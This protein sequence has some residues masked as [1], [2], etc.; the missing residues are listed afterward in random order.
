[1]SYKILFLDIDGTILKPDHKYTE[2][3]KEAIKQVKAK[4]IEVFFA[5]GRPLHEIEDL[6]EELEIESGIG[7]N[8]G[9]AKYKGEM[10][11][12]DAFRPE[13][14]EEISSLAKELGNELIFYTLGTNYLTD[15]EDPE[16]E[17]FIDLFTMKK[18]A[19]VPEDFS[20]A[21]YGLS[22][23]KVLPEHVAHYEKFDELYMSPVNV[24]R[25]KNSYDFIQKKT[26]KGTAIQQ[27]LEKL[28]ISP[29]EAIAFGD[30]MNDK[31]MLQLVGHSFA[32][33]N[34]H[35]NV[36]QY[37]KYKTTSVNEDGIYNGLKE[38]GLVK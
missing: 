30:G 24:G 19:R 16:M 13:L 32:M 4:G 33:G 29:D 2:S 27:V 8:G 11:V 5:T 25:L 21:V 26:N 37:A 35:P 6:A 9:Y 28:N 1:M 23:I 3:T 20:E 7:Y 22:S 18:N 17:Y 31:D 34:A 12:N 10:I 36:F 15:P 14:V 38:L